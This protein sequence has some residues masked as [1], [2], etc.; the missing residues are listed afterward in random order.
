[1]TKCWCWKRLVFVRVGQLSSS[2]SVF[3]CHSGAY[4]GSADHR[5]SKYRPLLRGRWSLHEAEM[6]VWRARFQF[7][8]LLLPRPCF[9]NILVLTTLVY[10]RL[11][12]SSASYCDQS[13]L[14]LFLP[15]LWSHSCYMFVWLCRLD[16][17]LIAWLMLLQVVGCGIVLIAVIGCQAIAIAGRTTLNSR[18]DPVRNP[19]ITEA[20]LKR[21]FEM[22]LFKWY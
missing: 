15:R 6:Q 17:K 7:C 5:Q 10:I 4:S 18:P 12:I 13:L 11:I 3:K 2:S 21:L 16:I 8:S 22:F 19:N 14:N 1:M 9:R 20:V